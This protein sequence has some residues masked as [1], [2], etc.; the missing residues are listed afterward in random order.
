MR[1][2]LLKKGDR[3]QL[4]VRTIGGWK[5]FGTVTEDQR[6]VYDGVWFAKDGDD[7]GDLLYGHCCA[8]PHEVALMRRPHSPRA[9]GRRLAALVKANA[10][11][12]PGLRQKRFIRPKGV[13]AGAFVVSVVY[14]VTA[15]GL[16]GGLRSFRTVR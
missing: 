13:L 6:T 4:E 7:P 8:C 3:I 14:V 10:L 5:G 15:I 11:E 9:S 16:C 2:R 12:P 1:R